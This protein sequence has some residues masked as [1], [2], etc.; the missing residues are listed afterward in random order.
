[1]RFR[2]LLYAAFVLSLASSALAEQ[3][4]V[5]FCID[6]DQDGWCDEEFTAYLES[7]GL[8]DMDLLQIAMEDHL[9]F[10]NWDDYLWAVSIEGYDFDFLP[11]FDGP[12]NVS[13]TD[14]DEIYIWYTG[15]NWWEASTAPNQPTVSG[16]SE[17]GGSE[18]SGTW[19]DSESG[20]GT[21]TGST[22][23]GTAP[24]GSAQV[25]TVSSWLRGY[26]VEVDGVQIGVEGTGSDV[27][28]GD[29]TFYVTGNQ[30]HD[31][32]VNHPQFWKTWE[33]FFLAGGSYTANIDVPGRVTQSG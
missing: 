9:M 24:S 3:V 33:D 18:G 4:S 32:K 20:S 15:W 12:E 16:S 8:T 13:L 19:P 27:S 14:G 28:D 26:T 31:I 25:T 10:S 17:S 7:Y 23:T 1:M 30:Q 2:I 5:N 22:M 29:Y 11:Q 6:G 21:G